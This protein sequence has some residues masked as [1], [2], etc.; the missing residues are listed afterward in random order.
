MNFSPI[1][2]EQQYL[3]IQ[4]YVKGH[5]DLSQFSSNAAAFCETDYPMCQSQITNPRHSYYR[6]VW[7]KETEIARFYFDVTPGHGASPCTVAD[8]KQLELFLD[9]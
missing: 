6:C 7:D 3:P 2:D 9:L 1:C 8:I 4:V 5:V